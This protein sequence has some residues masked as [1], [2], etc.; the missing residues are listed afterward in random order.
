MR[1]QGVGSTSR[2]VPREATRAHEGQ[3]RICVC[4]DSSV[5]VCVCVRT[6]VHACVCARVCA[7]VTVCASMGFTA[8]ESLVTHGRE[9]GWKDLLCKAGVTSQKSRPGQ[10]HYRHCPHHPLHDAS[11]LY[12]C[13]VSLRS[14]VHCCPNS[15]CVSI[16]CCCHAAATSPH[17]RQ[18]YYSHNN[19]DRTA[20]HIKAACCC[21]RTCAAM[22]LGVGAWPK[23]ANFLRINDGI[24][25][26]L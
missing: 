6:C 19:N 22:M 11:R 15:Q 4:E 16:T 9:L 7:H 21:H 8:N 17:H 13:L 26:G 14:A 25:N 3:L 24:H 5:R 12:Y 20:T 1:A 18:Q 2:V 23:S 10:V